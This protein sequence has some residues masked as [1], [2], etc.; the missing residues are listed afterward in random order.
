MGGRPHLLIAGIP[1][2]VEWTFLVII[3]VLGLSPEIPLN[4]TVAWVAIAFISVLVHELGHAFMFRRFG[5]ESSIT[6]TGFGG[7]TAPRRPLRERKQVIAVSLAGP[8]TTFI[9][10]GIPTL[11]LFQSDWATG[12][13]NRETL[14]LMLLLI[15]VGWSLLNLLPILPLDG[16]HVVE[17]LVGSRTAHIVSIAVAAPAALWA[18]SV[19]Q[20]FAAVFAVLFAVQNAAALSVT[21][22]V[23]Q[24]P[25]GTPQPQPPASHSPSPSTS[26]LPAPPAGA[27]RRFPPLLPSPKAA[28]AT[29]PAPQVVPATL[30]VHG[31]DAE[32]LA[33][34]HLGSG[35]PV[36]ARMMAARA[37]VS[38]SA[39]LQSAVALHDGA[40]VSALANLEQ[41][42][43]SQ[44]PLPAPYTNV[45][46]KEL[47]AAHLPLRLAQRLLARRGDDAIA[48]TLLLHAVLADNGFPRAAAQVAELCAADPRISRARALYEAA[49]DWAAAGDA[50]RAARRRDEAIEAGWKEPAGD[51]GPSAPRRREPLRRREGSSEGGDD[52]RGDGREIA[53]PE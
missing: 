22:R 43:A 14:V 49:R 29:P 41:A 52:A 27:A 18:F 4:L 31:R 45:L 24:R 47:V 37:G 20:P 28:P 53:A 9:L 38:A 11:V 48:G 50:T 15:N 5:V 1:V 16:G 19:N 2:R 3:A 8:L 7:F 34:S 36:T 12:D 17:Q 30:A 26:P 44:A 39:W 10:F 35:D 13:L 46:A 32:R 40:F 23:Q 21:N 6:L 33:W 51:A 42:F 25:G